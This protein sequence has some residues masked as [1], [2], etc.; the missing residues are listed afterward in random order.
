MEKETKKKKL[1][2]LR[3]DSPVDM[4]NSR[5]T[6]QQDFPLCK[7]ITILIDEKK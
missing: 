7:M 1:L 6:I 3:H 4:T 5:A 2:S